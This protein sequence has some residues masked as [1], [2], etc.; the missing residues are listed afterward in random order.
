M[1]SRRDWFEHC[2]PIEGLGDDAWYE[3]TDDPQGRKQ[4]SV[5]AGQG[6]YKVVLVHSSTA[7]ATDVTPLEERMGKILSRLGRL[8]SSPLSPPPQGSARIR[9]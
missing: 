8:R 7:R 4:L 1:K 6:M 5:V 3:V 2:T 9:P